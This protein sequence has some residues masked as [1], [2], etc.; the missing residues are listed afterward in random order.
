MDKN[1]CIWQ[2]EIGLKILIQNFWRHAGIKVVNLQYHSSVFS[3]PFLDIFIFFYIAFMNVV[4]E[5]S[6]ISLY[7][8]V[9]ISVELCTM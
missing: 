7:T 3:S 6:Q 9:A 8:V 1:V 4:T 5:I 2:P